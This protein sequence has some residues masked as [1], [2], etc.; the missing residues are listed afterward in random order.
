MASTSE[1]RSRAAEHPVNW[2]SYGFVLL[3]YDV[4]V[5]KCGGPQTC[6]MKSPSPACG[7]REGQKRPTAMTDR[8]RTTPSF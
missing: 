4:H 8:S 6:E 3:K 5:S 1:R 2:P 7:Q